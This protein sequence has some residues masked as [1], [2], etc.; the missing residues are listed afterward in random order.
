MHD[1]S[2]KERLCLDGEEAPSEEA[3]KSHIRGRLE[4]YSMIDSMNESRS[5]SLERLWTMYH[6]RTG[7]PISYVIPSRS[8]FSIRTYYDY[9]EFPGRE[10]DKS[11]ESEG[12]CFATTDGKLITCKHC[13]ADAATPFELTSD[14]ECD[15]HDPRSGKKLSSIPINLFERDDNHD[16][17]VCMLP[18]EL[19]GILAL[20][21]DTVNRPVVGQRV[22]AFGVLYEHGG[23]AREIDCRIDLAHADGAQ[24]RVAA[25]FIKGMSG[26]PVLN[27][28]GHVI[29]IVTQ[30]SAPENYT[31]DGYFLWIG[32]VLKNGRTSL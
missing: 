32:A 8:V 5:T 26:G 17:A 18:E 29:G 2:Y 21:V 30:G 6:D 25:P 1:E 23:E 24:Y 4:Y 20:P 22:R 11:V 13:I 31:H 12:S 9:A 19:K 27:R 3:F 28:Q 16:F 7:E 14:C 15:I 10:R